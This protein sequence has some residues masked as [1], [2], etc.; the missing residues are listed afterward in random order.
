MT[1]VIYDV[2]RKLIAES[3]NGEPLRLIGLALTD[4]D[5]DGFEQMSFIVDDRKEKMK[6]LDNALDSLRVRFGDDSV[7]RAGTMDVAK[8]VNRKHRAENNVTDND[9]NENNDNC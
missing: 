4:I 1:D 5:R 8:R 3:W 6:K 7:K 2:A 9:A